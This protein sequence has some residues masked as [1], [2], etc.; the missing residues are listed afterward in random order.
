MHAPELRVRAAQLE[1]IAEIRETRLLRKF[2]GL[3][4]RHMRGPGFDRVADR[5]DLGAVAEIHVE[6]GADDDGV[7]ALLALGR[8]HLRPGDDIHPALAEADRE[9]RMPL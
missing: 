5:R 3:G 1:R 8:D 7:E 2:F 6:A 4:G 9:A